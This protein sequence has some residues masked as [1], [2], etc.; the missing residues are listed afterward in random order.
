MQLNKLIKKEADKL[1]IDICRIT[2]GSELKKEKEILKKRKKNG[3]WPQPLTNQNIKE[4]TAPALHFSG[5]NSIIVAALSY[6]NSGGT[7]ILSNYVSREDYHNFLRDKLEAL[8]SQLQEKIEKDF[9][10]KIFVDT[11]PFLERA[12]ARRA[13]AGFI[14]KN[15]MLINPKYGS[16]LFLGEIFTDLQIKKDSSLDK[17]CGQCR[18]CIDNCEGGALK[19]E[20]LLDAADCISYLTQKKGILTENEIYKIGTHV[21]GCDACQI[22]CPY[23]KNRKETEK[24]EMHFFDRDLEYFLKLERKSPPAELKNTAISWRGIRIL[25]RNALISAAN[26]QREEYFYLIKEKLNDKSPIIRYYAARALIKINYKR[27][28]DL[29]AEYLRTE[30]KKYRDKI[31]NILRVEEESN[32]Y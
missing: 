15:T 23:N 12:I 16:Y 17:D 10:Y 28:Q 20:Y 14:G 21:W 19:A 13:G 8:V 22:K 5:L 25:I 7:K 24:K 30:N 4:L 32:G 26:E 18:I 6:N 1:N 11:A 27:S 2:D 9:S 29:I 31:K 3:Y